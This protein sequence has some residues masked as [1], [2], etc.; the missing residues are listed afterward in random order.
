MSHKIKLLNVLID[1]LSMQ[2][3]LR[4][5][6]NTITKQQQLHHV[7]V[8]A[9]KIVAM[10]KDLELRKSV[11][12]SDLINAD[13]QAVVWASKFLRKPLKERV[14][15]IDLMTNLVGMAY[16]KGYKIFFFGAKEEVVMKVVEKYKE[17]YSPDIIAGYRNGYFK[18]EEEKDIARQISDSG[19]H[20]LFVA[21][22]SPT[23][24]NFLYQ[25]RK[26]LSGVNFIMGVGGSFDVVAGKVKR[27]PIW[28]QKAGLEWFYRFLQEPGRMWKRYLIGNTK[29]ILLVLKEKFSSSQ[30]SS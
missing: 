20:M 13:G 7:V 5:I 30:F 10:Q 17:Q 19:A 18:K 4:E 21:I 15:G 22:S 9:G 14:A 23:K 6:E 3:T 11:N 24:E 29:F 26:L 2:E 1:N 25:N 12:E 16:E 27:A 8:N 28:M